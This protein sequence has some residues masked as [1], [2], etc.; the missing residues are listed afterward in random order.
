MAKVLPHQDPIG[1]SIRIA[2]PDGFGLVDGRIEI[3]G[4]VGHVKH[5]GL[6]LTPPPRSS[7]RLTCHWS[8][9]PTR[10][11]V[12]GGM[13]MILYGSSAS[14]LSL[15]SALPPYFNKDSEEPLFDVQTMDRRVMD[16]V[17]G[18]CFSMPLLGVFAGTGLGAGVGGDYE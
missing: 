8:N 5:F 2:A 12:A 15:V 9:C 11:L 3:A 7:T 14:L 18:C 10:S 4:V 13:T 16:S 17:V 6:T 1:Q